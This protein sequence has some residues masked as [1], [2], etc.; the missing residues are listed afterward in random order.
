MSTTANM[1]GLAREVRNYFCALDTKPISCL[2]PE[3]FNVKY[4][5]MN[6]KQLKEIQ[7]LFYEQIT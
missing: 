3:E 5:T 2:A 7:Q 4:G 6:L 1:R